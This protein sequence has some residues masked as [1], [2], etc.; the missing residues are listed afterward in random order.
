[1]A[2]Q[3]HRGLPRSVELDDLIAYGQVGLHEA[4]A[5]Y[6]PERGGKFTTF[7]YY[8][9]RGAIFDGLSKMVW[10]NREQQRRSRYERGAAELL[11]MEAEDASSAER[12]E[13]D[14]DWLERVSSGLAMVHWVSRADDESDGCG[15]LVD[16]DTATPDRLLMDRE[17]SQIL[18]RLLD[19]LPADAGLLIRSI[20]YHGETLQE[21]GRRIGIS[22]AWAS[23]LHAKT[24]ERLARALRA[25]KAE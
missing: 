21:A 6:E 7:A 14:A 22:K 4:A 19:G 2:G 12:N 15:N 17:M 18:S 25:E 24:L 11:K 8:R 10:M 3:I 23:R 20:Y 5:A 13:H 9:I 1:L 16:H